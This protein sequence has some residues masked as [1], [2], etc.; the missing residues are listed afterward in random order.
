MSSGKESILVGAVRKFQKSFQGMNHS[1]INEYLQM[2]RADWITWISNPSTASHMSEVW[3]RQIRNIRG[4]AN[5]LFKTHEK[6]LANELARSYSKLE[7]NDGGN[8][9]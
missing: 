7:T 5:A 9:Q 8:H 6:I 4:V 1:S 2:Y 3:E